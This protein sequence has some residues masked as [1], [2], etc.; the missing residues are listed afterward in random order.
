MSNAMKALVIVL[1]W[2]EKLRRQDYP[3][4][5]QTITSDDWHHILG[6]K[7]GPRRQYV[8]VGYFDNLD[9]WGPDGWSITTFENVSVIEKARYTHKQFRPGP[10]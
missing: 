3:R 9:G 2:Q 6:A 5:D 1:N 4:N 8:A 10:L 7:F